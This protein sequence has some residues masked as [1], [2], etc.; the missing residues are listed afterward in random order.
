MS[1]VCDCRL[2]IADWGFASTGCGMLWPEMT[3]EANSSR[4]PAGSQRP[5]AP[6]EANFDAGGILITGSPENSYKKTHAWRCRENEANWV[7]VCGGGSGPQGRDCFGA[8]LLAMTR[9]GRDPTMPNKA[10]SPGSWRPREIRSSKLDIRN[11]SEMQM[12]KTDHSAPNEPNL[13]RFWPQNE[14]GVANKAHWVPVW[15]DGTGP[16]GRDCFGASLLAMTRASRHPVMSNKANLATRRPVPVQISRHLAW[17]PPP[18]PVETPVVIPA[19][20]GIQ[21]ASAVCWTPAF[22]AVTKSAFHA[23]IWNRQ[24]ALAY[25]PALRDKPNFQGAEM[26]NKANLGPYICWIARDGAGLAAGGNGTGGVVRN[27]P[28][29]RWR[30]DLAAWGCIL[31]G[32]FGQ[33]R[34]KRGLNAACMQ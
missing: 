19:E 9:A 13:P 33:E 17:G 25:T 10:N 4:R 30:L 31:S 3:N 8:S 11:K 26:A 5:A 20:A 18:G 24:G 7:P 23:G 2:G 29:P 21:G 14:G 32:R 16:Q 1:Q 22:A 6:N 34:S 28:K 27:E 12:L 15:C